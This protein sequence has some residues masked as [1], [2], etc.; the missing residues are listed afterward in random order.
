MGNTIIIIILVAVAALA[1][2]KTRKHFQ[3]GSCCGS[4]GN[5]I[6][7]HKKLDAP[8]IGKKTLSIDGIHCENCQARIENT[9]N[10]LDGVACQVNLHKKTATV[11]YSREISNQELKERIEKLGYTVT[12]IRQTD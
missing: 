5:T 9:L 11:S 4:G 1:L 8:A 10:R 7:T 12:D 6:R 2:I 3:G